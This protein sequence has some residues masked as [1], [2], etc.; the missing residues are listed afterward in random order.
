MSCQEL[1]IGTNI[2]YILVDDSIY[3]G[4]HSTCI[5]LLFNIVECCKNKVCKNNAIIK[6]YEIFDQKTKGC[7][8]RIFYDKWYKEMHKRK[9]FITRELAANI[10]PK[11]QQDYVKF[12]QTAYNCNSKIFVTQK[13]DLLKKGEEILKEYG[14]QTLNIAEANEK[15]IKFENESDVRAII[16]EGETHTVEFKSSL[17][18]DYY[19]NILNSNLEF[20]IPK[21]IAAFLNTKG[22][23]LF[24]GLG[25]DGNILGLEKD[26]GTLGKKNR[27]GFKLKLV[28]IISKYLGK[29]FNDP[30]YFTMEI[31]EVDNKDICLIMVSKSDRPIY[32]KKNSDEFFFI[33]TAAST[34][35]LNTRQTIDYIKSHW[36]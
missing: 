20:E 22:G 2:F 29:E 10:H 21:N 14:I 7:K 5:S 36:P 24:I 34:I 31:I 27:D 1:V 33:R 12:Y 23:K 4:H 19:Q 18:Y 8:Y 17:R 11:V 6:E 30:K 15:V 25:D 28:E 13:I 16:S 9:K 3:P 26:Y 35:K 32:V